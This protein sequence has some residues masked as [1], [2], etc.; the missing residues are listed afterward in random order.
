MVY[1]LIRN[2][3]Q[4]F[5]SIPKTKKACDRSNQWRHDLW[6]FDLEKPLKNICLCTSCAVE[7]S[8]RY[9]P[10]MYAH[11]QLCSAGIIGVF[12]KNC[13]LTVWPEIHRPHSLKVVKIPLY[14]LVSRL[15][16]GHGA[17]RPG[18]PGPAIAIIYK[19]KALQYNSSCE[20]VAREGI[21]TRVCTVVFTPWSHKRPSIALTVRWN[22]NPF[23]WTSGAPS[24][25]NL[26]KSK[27]MLIHNIV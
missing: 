23:C 2:L 27:R 16:G 4:E 15:I 18:R 22:R 24:A 13:P 14:K 8:G 6:I 12:L 21:N 20:P 25:K 7:L 11:V 1:L 17:G 19:T 10:S 26:P 3:W 5:T 9:I